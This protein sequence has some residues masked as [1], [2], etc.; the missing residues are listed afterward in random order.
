[1]RFERAT[2]YDEFAMAQKYAAKK[3]AELLQKHARTFRNAYEIGCGSGIFTRELERFDIGQLTL[4]DLYRALPMQGRP[5]QVGDIREIDLP[6]NLD[7]VA[8]SSVLQWIDDLDPLFEKIRQAMLPGGIFAFAIFT[9][10]TLHELSSFTGQGLVYKSDSRIQSIAETHFRVLEASPDACLVSFSSLHDLL[11]SLKQTGVNNLKGPFRLTR[12]SLQKM[13]EHF[14]GNYS[15]SY[16]F[17][18]IVAQ[19]IG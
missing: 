13:R 10:G 19:K 16:R 8:S 7:L 1:M 5:A 15:L 4:N 6:Q 9:E 11:D 12:D 2:R 18:A 3:L 14:A 17:Q